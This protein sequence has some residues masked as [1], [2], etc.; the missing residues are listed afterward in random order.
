MRLREQKTNNN[1]E[2]FTSTSDIVL[3][4]TLGMTAEK[5]SVWSSEIKSKEIVGD[6]KK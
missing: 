4:L 5:N 3:L 6:A 2:Q 1:H